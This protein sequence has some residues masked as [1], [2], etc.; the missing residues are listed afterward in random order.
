[1][2]FSTK[3][4]YS[5]SKILDNKRIYNIKGGVL[6]EKKKLMV[7]VITSHQKLGIF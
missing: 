2:R 3:L 7:R 1:M 5:Y 4:L 6:N